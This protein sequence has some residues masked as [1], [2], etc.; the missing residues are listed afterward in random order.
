[1]IGAGAAKTGSFLIRAGIEEEEGV[2][3]LAETEGRNVGRRREDWEGEREVRHPPL[4]EAV[5]IAQG[6]QELR[7]FIPFLTTLL[8][9]ILCYRDN[10]SESLVNQNFLFLPF[11]LGLDVGDSMQILL[12]AYI[13][14]AIFN[15]FN[16]IIYQLIHIYIRTYMIIS[17]KPCIHCLFS[18]LIYNGVIIIN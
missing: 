10:E 11:R 13:T 1:M 15:V 12:S 14:S 5:D 16:Y 2:L 9:Y 4:I 7:D 6:T 18:T 8:C 17:C 3:S